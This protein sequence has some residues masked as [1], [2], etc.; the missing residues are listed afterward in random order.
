MIAY[1]LIYPLFAIAT[2]CIALAIVLIAPLQSLQAR[3]LALMIASI[4][5]YMCI[6][7]GLHDIQLATLMLITGILGA[8]ALDNFSLQPKVKYGVVMA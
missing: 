3:T 8:I 5:T 7:A 4:A 6:A 1:E 2:L